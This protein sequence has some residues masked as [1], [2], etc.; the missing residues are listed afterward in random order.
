MAEPHTPQW[1]I[2]APGPSGPRTLYCFPHGGGS[3]AEYVRWGRQ[4]EGLNVLAVQLPGRGSRLDEEPCTSMA[5]LVDRLAKELPLSTP[6]VFFGHSFGALVCYELTHRLIEL[7]RPLPERLILSGYPAPELARHEQGFHLLPDTELLGA[8]NERHGGIPEE[9]LA[10]PELARL[11]AAGLR[12]DY[13]ILET[14]RWY[15]R[16]PLPVPFTV[17]GGDRDLISREQ[18]TAWERHTDAGPVQVRLFPGGHFYFR[19][20]QHAA[21]L[22][23]VR[24]AAAC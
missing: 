8:V 23:N 2:R 13:R 12:A 20:R 3:A 14:Y 24:A 19:E 10:D 21:V 4:L 1:T 22:R 18:L 16:P 15:E 7:G 5:D 17:L 11:S 6:F 9:L